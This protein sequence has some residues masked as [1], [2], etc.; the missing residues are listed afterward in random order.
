M[1]ELIDQEFP[2]E[3]LPLVELAISGGNLILEVRYIIVMR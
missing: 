3:L 2:I 1:T